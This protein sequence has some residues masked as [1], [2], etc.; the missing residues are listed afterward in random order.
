MLRDPPVQTWDMMVVTWLQ[1]S[2]A[3]LPLAGAAVVL[4]LRDWNLLLQA[5]ELYADARVQAWMAEDGPRI[6]KTQQ[7]MSL[8]RA[9]AAGAHGAAGAKPRLLNWE[10]WRQRL[11]QVPA[12]SWPGETLNRF[13]LPKSE[14]HVKMRGKVYA[15]P[16]LVYGEAKD[17]GL[18]GGVIVLLL[19]I[20]SASILSPSPRG[21]G[22]ELVLGIG[23]LVLA[24]GVAPQAIVQM[25]D[26]RAVRR[27]RWQVIGCFLLVFDSVLALML[28][29]AFAGVLIQPGDINLTMYAIAGVLPASIEPVI[30]DPLGYVV[31]AIAGAFLIFFVAAP[32]LL[33][34]LLSLDFA[35]KQRVLRWYGAPW[36][37]QRS[38]PIMLAISGVLATAVWFGIAPLLSLAAFPGILT[39]DWGLVGGLVL[40]ALLGGGLAIWIRRHD[41]HYRDL[42]PHCGETVGVT[43]QLGQT[44]P[45]CR[46][47]LQQWLTA[48][49]QERPAG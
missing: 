3:I 35:L 39:L 49:Q 8:A 25:P 47:S 38:T 33:Y 14:P 10:E 17:I 23:F 32:L 24:T 44:C 36:L 41:R 43:F 19:F 1:L 40:A 7:W 42:C 15:E 46:H 45:H 11:A 28:A 5:R 22:A 26:L 20:V 31:Q 48:P 16:H 21:F 18:R 37:P 12:L 2:M 29:V 9:S 27:T 13:F 4:L 30:A 34:G 6:A